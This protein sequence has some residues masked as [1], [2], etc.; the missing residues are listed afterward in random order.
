MVAP[1]AT[2]V[3]AEAIL[4]LRSNS[5]FQRNKR[6][7]A[8][9]LKTYRGNCHCGAVRFEADIETP[10]GK[11]YGINLGCLEDVSEEELARAPTPTSMV[12]MTSGR[13]PLNSSATCERKCLGLLTFSINVPL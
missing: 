7:G 10:I 8:K 4:D 5:A 13:A 3:M 1:A 6:M 12:A 9:M 2:E 11:M